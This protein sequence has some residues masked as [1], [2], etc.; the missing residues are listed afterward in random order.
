MRVVLGFCFILAVQALLAPSANGQEVIK[1]LRDYRSNTPRNYTPTDP[2]ERGR[3]FNMHTGH[4]GAFYNCDDEEAKR[5][6]PYICWKGTYQKSTPHRGLWRGLKMDIAEVKQRIHDGGCGTCQGDCECQA[7][8][9]PAQ[10]QPSDCFVCQN[11]GADVVEAE[12]VVVAQTERVRQS[13]TVSA[14]QDV[15]ARFAVGSGESASTKMARSMLRNS[16]ESTNI[17][18]LRSAAHRSASELSANPIKVELPRYGLV[19]GS[20]LK[21]ESIAEK[22]Q[23]K[24]EATKSRWAEKL[25]SLSRRR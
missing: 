10:H 8:T 14:L 15:K 6:S 9:Q 23:A 3:I 17:D 4:A 2:N 13:S 12:Q 1:A 21:P 11:G 22:A 5:N 18:A 24:V 16:S 7:C 19:S 25:E 20:S